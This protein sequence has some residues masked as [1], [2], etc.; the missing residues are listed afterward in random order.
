MKA[1]SRAN[2]PLNRNRHSQ[3]AVN[4]R[5]LDF[6]CFKIKMQENVTKNRYYKTKCGKYNLQKFHKVDRNLCYTITYL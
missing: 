1:C 4:E 6:S 2:K 5:D 3:T